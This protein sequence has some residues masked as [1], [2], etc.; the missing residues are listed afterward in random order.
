MLPEKYVGVDVP[1]MVGARVMMSERYKSLF[2]VT[3]GGTNT[4]IGSIFYEPQTDCSR[5]GAGIIEEVWDE[6][7]WCRVKWDST[8]ETGT[9]W[10]A[11]MWTCIPHTTG[12]HVQGKIGCSP[13]ILL[14]SAERRESS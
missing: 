14:D 5:G 13:L 2:P 7:A 10:I 6:G 9:Y 8:G 12:G 4:H 1:C 3:P 11:S